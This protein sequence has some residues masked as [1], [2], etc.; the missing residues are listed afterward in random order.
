MIYLTM[1]TRELRRTPASF[2]PSTWMYILGILSIIKD[3]RGH[4]L[5]SSWI[6]V[7]A[8]LLEPWSSWGI[9]KQKLYDLKLV[10]V[11]GTS[12]ISRT[13][14]RTRVSRTHR[15]T[16]ISRTYEG[17]RI[18]RIPRMETYGDTAHCSTQGI[19]LGT[20]QTVSKANISEILGI[21]Y[22]RL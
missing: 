1:T 14:R 4:S 11:T 2:H 16:R 7:W 22:Q 19:T 5:F 20:A 9:Y 6:Y 17:T 21:A 3:I 10:L 13:D 18:T 15:R 12:R 8:E